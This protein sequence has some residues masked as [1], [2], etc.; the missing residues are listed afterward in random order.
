MA[1]QTVDKLVIDGYDLTAEKTRYHF[2]DVTGRGV[3]I[4]RGTAVVKIRGE[5]ENSRYQQARV[6]H[7][8]RMFLTTHDDDSPVLELGYPTAGSYVACGEGVYYDA[9]LGCAQKLFDDNH[10]YLRDAVAA[11]LENGLLLRREIN[12]DDFLV[13]ADG[14]DDVHTPQDLAELIHN[15]TKER[16]PSREGWKIFLCNSGAEANE[17]SIKLAMLVKWRKLEEKY[18]RRNVERLMD[19]LGIKKNETLEAR[20]K[21]RDEPVY[22]DYP[23]FLVATA[24]AFHGRTLGALSLT[25]SKKAHQIGYQKFHYVKHVE[26]NK[27]PQCLRALIDPRPLDQILDSEGGV[28]KVLDRGKI[29]ADLCAAFI[30]EGFQGEGGYL[31]GDPVWFHGIG[32]AAKEFGVMLL[33]DEVQSWARTGKLYSWEHFDCA[34]DAIAI[35]KSAFLGI[36]VARGEYSRYLHH[37]WH[38]NTFGG[39]KVFDVNIAYATHDALLNYRAPHLNEISHFENEEIKGKYLRSQIEK[40]REKHKDIIVGCTGRGVM[41]GLEV[42]RRADVAR[43]G[44]SRGLKVLSA[45]LPTGDTA[46]I[47]LIHLADVTTK[48]ID[49]LVKVLEDVCY[50]VARGE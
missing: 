20:D 11:L 1:I 46:K 12:T 36:M 28:A 22:K 42:R 29:P 35:A 2:P 50:G 7:N 43:V 18:G 25:Q 4:N 13:Q 45:G 37:G 44:W 9:M 34:P 40:L 31:P 24:G 21:T 27:D 23:M 16:F 26:Y 5:M 19:Q 41:N 10:P 14:L 49:D 17:A 15:A 39:G 3:T 48:E 30:A 8:A 6:A 38:S 32:K 33:A 47:R